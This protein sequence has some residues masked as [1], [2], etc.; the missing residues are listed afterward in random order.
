[1]GGRRYVGT[2]KLVEVFVWVIAVEMRVVVLHFQV[3]LYVFV[4]FVPS[5]NQP[6]DSANAI[7]IH[8]RLDSRHISAKICQI[9]LAEIDARLGGIVTNSLEIVLYRAT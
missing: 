9:V 5:N 6:F 7:T 8:V 4:L 1:M 2:P 3:I